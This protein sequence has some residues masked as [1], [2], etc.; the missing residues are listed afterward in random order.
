MGPIGETGYTGP[1]GSI[2]ETGS[3]GPQGIQGETGPTGDTG[4][5]GA[6]SFIPGPMGEIGPTGATGDTGPIGEP[7]MIPGPI[8]DTGPTGATGDTGA[9]GIQGEAS[10]VTGPTGYTGPQGNI[11]ETGPTGDTGAASTVTGPTGD[12]GPAGETGPTGA[13]G[14]G[15]QWKDSVANEAALPVNTDFAFLTQDV[16]TNLGPDFISS[17]IT[18]IGDD[19]V[20]R[21]I[22]I[23][24]FRLKLDVTVSGATIRAFVY[25]S[26]GLDPNAQIAQC[27]SDIVVAS[28]VNNG[29][30]DFVFTDLPATDGVTFW[31]LIRRV[32]GTGTIKP[33]YNSATGNLVY[34]SS[35]NG[36]SHYGALYLTAYLTSIQSLEGDA[37]YAET[38]KTFH[39]FDGTDWLQQI[40]P[41][42]PTGDTGPTGADSTVTGP[43]GDTGPAGETGPTGA[44]GPTG[45][46]GI[47]G[48]TGA[49]GYFIN[50]YKGMIAL[51][52]D[53]PTPEDYDDAAAAIS[54]ANA[55]TVGDAQAQIY[56]A[57]P[58][59]VGPVTL[60]STTTQVNVYIRYKAPD[61][62]FAGTV[63]LL[64]YIGENN[65]GEAIHTEA[66]T[67]ENNA[68]FVK[69]GLIGLEGSFPAGQYMIKITNADS[70]YGTS[71][72]D[73][74]T[75]A[76]AIGFWQ[77]YSSVRVSDYDPCVTVLATSVFAYDDGDI[78][79]T[80]DT[81][82]F[83]RWDSELG[84]GE[85]VNVTAIGPT[86][87]TGDTGPTGASSTVTGP[88]GPA[89]SAGETGPT[90]P[91][92]SAEE[93]GDVHWKA[94]VADEAALP[95]NEETLILD[96]KDSGVSFYD[97]VT[98]SGQFCAG[99]FVG[100]GY[101]TYR[102]DFNTQVMFN[103]N[104]V[105]TPTIHTDNA[106]SPGT[107]VT[108]GTNVTI[109]GD[110]SVQNFDKEIEFA[111]LDLTAEATYW[112]K[113]T[114]VAG[115]DRKS[116]V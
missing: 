74:N 105:V 30:Y 47:T 67:W 8:G 25:T 90:G 7:S 18:T 35:L 89:G 28:P 65:F 86:G 39:I 100:A 81:N 19:F 77:F 50:N 16:D 69:S 11:G 95:V 113:F 64:P 2:G 115:L 37:R 61:G 60:N 70:T 111:D 6:D 21:G 116:V 68:D 32:D 94:P 57:W 10:T 27:D 15:T 23:Y 1:Q 98:G 26:D 43:T 44:D 46:A 87:P 14:S 34:G 82:R 53:L 103:G 92:G 3:T 31:I 49:T 93:A 42:G 80:E 114:W 51:E 40:G 29:V 13:V 58:L 4:P 75:R 85:W 41:T 97:Y 62:P 5:Q 20:G 84:V 99:T 52:A 12:T 88:T 104:T 63:Q 96:Q 36:W 48:A 24:K 83:W 79:F 106:G 45:P 66:F 56:N 73:M 22:G 33:H 110:G 101:G 78:L 55:D 17:D 107:L 38:E 54:E 76:G 9:Q 112:I 71:N 102:F 59:A 109:S 72:I 108:T 91:A